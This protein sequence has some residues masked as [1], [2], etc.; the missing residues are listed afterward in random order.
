MQEEGATVS[1]AG[2]SHKALLEDVIHP[3]L[4]NEQDMAGSRKG[5]K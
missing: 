4:K 2:A 5:K 3:E 1:S